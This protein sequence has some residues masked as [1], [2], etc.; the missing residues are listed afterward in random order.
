MH[1]YEGRS[2]KKTVRT[3][4]IGG[5]GAGVPRHIRS[6][7]CLIRK[8]SVLSIYVSEKKSDKCFTYLYIHNVR[9]S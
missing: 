4:I 3:G 5:L 6:E 9:L 1:L 7:N 8:P 2:V